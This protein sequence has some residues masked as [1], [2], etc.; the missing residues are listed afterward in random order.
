MKELNYGCPMGFAVITGIVLIIVI[1]YTIIMLR[2]QVSKK[3][4]SPN[5]NKKT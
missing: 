2:R 4:D 1:I 5:K 3:E